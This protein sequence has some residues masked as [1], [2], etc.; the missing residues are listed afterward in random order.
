MQLFAYLLFNTES[1]LPYMGRFRE[2]ILVLANPLKEYCTKTRFLFIFYFLV[3]FLSGATVA[4]QSISYTDTHTQRPFTLPV[5]LG[6]SKIP[7]KD[8]T[9]YLSPIY[10]C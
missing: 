10:R 3:L 4:F 9:N 2:R 5:A 7:R 6:Q 8:F 1:E